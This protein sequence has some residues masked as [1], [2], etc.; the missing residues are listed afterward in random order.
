[1]YPRLG[2]WSFSY[3]NQSISTEGRY[4]WLS[5]DSKVCFSCIQIHHVTLGK[6]FN[7]CEPRFPHL[8]N[9]DLVFKE[10]HFE[11]Y[12]SDTRDEVVNNTEKSLPS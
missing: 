6:L 4:N 3:M 8:H 10:I 5:L 9:Q 1:M 12:V 11:H 2:S 7:L